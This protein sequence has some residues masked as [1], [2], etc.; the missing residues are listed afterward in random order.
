M[1]NRYVTAFEQYDID[2]LTALFRQDATISMP[3]YALWFQGHE[4]IRNW[5]L[6]LGVAAAG[7]DCCP[8]QP[9]V[10]QRSRSIA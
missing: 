4:A 3:P 10:P 9:V 8:P 1:L 7:R 5:M 6:G 2:A